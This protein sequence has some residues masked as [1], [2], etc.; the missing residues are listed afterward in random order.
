MHS[1]FTYAQSRFTFHA[2]IWAPNSLLNPIPFYVSRFTLC[3]LIKPERLSEVKTRY[4]DS[5][6]QQFG[7]AAFTVVVLAGYAIWITGASFQFDIS[8]L[9]LMSLLGLVYLAL[10]TWGEQYIDRFPFAWS[11]PAYFIIQLG[12][13]GA[14]NF[15]S[16]GNVWLILLPLASQAVERLPSPWSFIVAAAVWVL[17]AAPFVIQNGWEN[18]VPFA[19]P[20]LAAVVFVVVFTQ[21]T[22]SEQQARKKLAQ[23]NQQL[24]EFAAQA[25]E[26][27]T[28]QER[29]RLA[30]EIHDGLG[31][32]LTA[33]NI[34]IRAAQAF[35]E[36]DRA[37][38]R[39]ALTNAQT[40]AEEALADVRRSI[41]ELRTDPS[42]ASPLAERLKILMEETRAAG[43][44]AEMEVEGTPAPL[45]PQADFTLFRVTQEGLTNVRKHSN[46]TQAEL[47]LAYLERTVRLVVCDNGIGTQDLSGGFGLTGLQE[48]VQ[49]VGGTI[50]VETAPGQGFR[51]E[52][53]IPKQAAQT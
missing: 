16:K 2:S 4:A 10:G 33:I 39:E 53:E 24:R 23:A 48:R 40:L 15:L 51:L 26:M 30:R 37:Q 41:S 38:A 45:S 44:Q 35:I 36:Q 7:N 9:V 20:L 22:V 5:S 1:P 3:G 46:A 18:F 49:L 17:Q 42:T 29:N 43:I 50:K 31:H 32:Y 19:M 27:A 47:H 25:E 34:Q 28:V 52:V 8:N 6:S 12:L 13:V 11:R 14:I 21:I